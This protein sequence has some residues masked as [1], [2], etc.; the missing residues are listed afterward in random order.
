MFGEYTPLMKAGLLQRRLLNGKAEIDPELGLQKLCPHCQE[1]WP[2]DTLFWAPS[3]S[4]P[5]GLQCWCKAC[6]LEYK[7]SRRKAA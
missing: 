7:N 6:Q 2:Q 5:D 1:F 4:E 3:H